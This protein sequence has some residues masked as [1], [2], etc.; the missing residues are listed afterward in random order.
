MMI[1]CG[2][3]AQAAMRR[4][5]LS[6]ARLSH[7]FISHMHGDHCLGLPGLLSTLSL[8]GRENPVTIYL[9][10]EGVEI[11]RKITDFF[12]RQSTYQIQFVPVGGRGGLLLDMPSFTVEAFPLFHRVPAYG[13]IFRE[14]PK[15]RHLRGDMLEF[16]NVPIA[17]RPAI[18]NGADFV[19]PDGTVI[20]N[21]RLTTPPDH[22]LSYAYC[23][24]TMFN[25]LVARAVTDVDVLY[26]EATYDSSLEEKAVQRGHSTARQ[27]GRIAAMAS[28][29]ALII[30]H[31]SKRYDE[32]DILVDEA[33]E[34]FHTVVPA[35][36]RLQIPLDKLAFGH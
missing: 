29:K 9:P 21:S 4:M 33:R 22:S 26:H 15:L 6:F 2:E 13:Y 1:D 35:A 7:I 8:H 18:K 34:E 23:S 5:S 3:G 16:F 28:V 12:C 17:Q 10:A 25:P 14:K 32:V 30:G 24:D 20:A 19:T 31:Y 27:A 11:M 36:D